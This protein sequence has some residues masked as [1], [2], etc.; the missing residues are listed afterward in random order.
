MALDCTAWC[1]YNAVN[2]LQIIQERHPIAH[3]SGELWGVFCGFSLWLILCLS[4]NNDVCNILLCWTVSLGRRTPKTPTSETPDFGGHVTS[5]T[6][7]YL[8]PRPL[9]RAWLQAGAQRVVIV[10]LPPL[11]SLG[12]DSRNVIMALDCT[13][14]YPKIAF[15][16][17]CGAIITWLLFS[18]VHVYD[19]LQFDLK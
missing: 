12:I 3:L 19:L 15:I 18:H 16:A 9:G 5:L 2:T 6:L 13:Y 7:Q 1:R 17:Q 14:S 8:W 10:V 11:N 4:S